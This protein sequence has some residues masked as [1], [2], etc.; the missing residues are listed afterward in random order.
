MVCW[1]EC[2]PEPSG[3]AR[4]KTSNT[5]SCRRY[6]ERLAAEN[7]HLKLRA[8]GAG[9]GGGGGVL[10]LIVNYL[11]KI[12]SFWFVFVILIQANRMFS[13]LKIGEM[14]FCCN[15]DVIQKFVSF[16]FYDLLLNA[17]WKKLLTVFLHALV[18]LIIVYCMKGCVTCYIKK[19]ELW[20]YVAHLILQQSTC[21][22]HV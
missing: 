19:I 14:L 9:E 8:W 13:M 11:D 3:T 16:N 15:T 17:N 21:H 22:N 18:W 10:D 20:L 6:R 2:T 4:R 1:T 7:P 5:D 12:R